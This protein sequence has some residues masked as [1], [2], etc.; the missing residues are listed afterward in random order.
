MIGLGA[1]AARGEVVGQFGADA[2]R[3]VLTI[4]ALAELE[5]ALAVPDLMALLERF[6]GGRISA[7]EAALVVMAGLKGGGLRLDEAALERLVAGRPAMETIGN[8]ARL[9]NASFG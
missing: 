7:R 5:A 4:G 3:L 9:L 6:A 2:H 8:A 1:N